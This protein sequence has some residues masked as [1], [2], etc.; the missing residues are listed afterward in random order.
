MN[1]EPISIELGM[2]SESRAPA[3]PWQGAR[4]EWMPGLDRANSVAWTRRLLWVYFIMLLSEGAL[5]K[6]VLPQFSA[7]LAIMRDPVLLLAMFFALRGGFFPWNLWTLTL[8]LIAMFSLVAGLMAEGNTVTV[9]LFGM[10]TTFMHFYLV[11][12]MPMVFRQKDLYRIGKVCLWFVIPTGILMLYQFLSSPDDWINVA[13]GGEG[14]QIGGTAGNIRPPGFFAF[15]TGIAEFFSLA[16]AFLLMAAVVPKLFPPWVV[17]SSAMC[18]LLGVSVSISRLTLLSIALVLF[19][20]FILAIYRPHLMPGGVILGVMGAVA[21]LFLAEFEGIQKGLNAFNQR[22]DDASSAEG[23]LA[24]FMLRLGN[25]F[26]EP[27]MQMESVPL[28]GHGLG[29]GTNAGARLLTGQ[30]GF[31]LAEG[32][33][34]RVVMESGYVMGPLMIVWRVILTLWLGFRAWRCAMLGYPLAWFLWGAAAQL[35][36]IGQLGR[37]TTLGFTAWIAALCYTAT[38]LRVKE[39]ANSYAWHP[40]RG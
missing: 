19:M 5:R 16:S 38:C 40:E 27:W 18:M 34:A 24:G 28:E 22:V 25:V 3:G 23:G 15:I 4:P 6:W 33:W 9:A 26:T 12:L 21:F 14:Q 39:G 1:P 35:I 11:F 20:F 32:E 2:I 8:T 29:M 13:T 7:P 31:L 10:R 30:V 36:L 17:L 37:P